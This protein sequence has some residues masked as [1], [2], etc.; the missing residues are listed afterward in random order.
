MFPVWKRL[1]QLVI[2]IETEKQQ[3]LL[4]EISLVPKMELALHV[5]QYIFDA[6]EKELDYS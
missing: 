1:C 3:Q 2:T 5:I 4:G 6:V